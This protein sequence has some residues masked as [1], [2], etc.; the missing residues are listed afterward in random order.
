[1]S[2]FLSHIQTFVF[3]LYTEIGYIIYPKGLNSAP[4]IWRKD[5]GA[6]KKMFLTTLKISLKLDNSLILGI[7]FFFNQR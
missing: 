7:Y 5:K 2:L 6:E 4:N 1:M 3:L